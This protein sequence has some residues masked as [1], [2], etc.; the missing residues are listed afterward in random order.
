MTPRTVNNILIIVAII[1]SVITLG[2]IYEYTEYR[3]IGGMKYPPK[4]WAVLTDGK[5]FKYR[6]SN[7]VEGIKKYTYQS[8]VNAAW[9]DFEVMVKEGNTVWT[10]VNPPIQAPI[11]I[12]AIETT[13][14]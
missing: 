13:G 9:V 7:G 6:T 5:V 2:C 3:K 4:H 10:V 1:L 8:A 12:E 14:K 11:I